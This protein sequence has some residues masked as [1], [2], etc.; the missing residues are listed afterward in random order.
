MA[1]LRDIDNEGL[2]QIVGKGLVETIVSHDIIGRLMIKCARQKGLADAYEMFLG[3]EGDEFYLSRWPSM[4]GKRF[5]DL[6][7]HFPNAVCHVGEPCL[8]ICM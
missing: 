6:Y 8:R 3:F 2:V 5:D 1:E 7:R 4:V